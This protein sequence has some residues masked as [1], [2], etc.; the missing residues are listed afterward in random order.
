MAS[1]RKAIDATEVF[2][3]G[4]P[5]RLTVEPGSD[6]PTPKPGSGLRTRLKEVLDR[7]PA[8]SDLP[9]WEDGGKR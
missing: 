4:Q 8:V 7:V 3:D 6:L 5:V 1:D 2:V 9:R